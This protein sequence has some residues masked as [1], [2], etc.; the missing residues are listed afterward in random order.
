MELDESDITTILIY[1]DIVASAP[2][3]ASKFNV[4]LNPTESL[5]S[6][7]LNIHV[8]IHHQHTEIM[9]NPQ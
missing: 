5:F 2:H 9:H 1:L 4:Y 8:R 3:Q 6:M 7:K